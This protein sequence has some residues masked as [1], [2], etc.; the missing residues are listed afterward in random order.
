MLCYVKPD[1]DCL[2]SQAFQDPATT[3]S[4]VAKAKGCG[5]AAFTHSQSEV[6]IPWR[7]L[8]PVC[9]SPPRLLLLHQSLRSHGLT[10][11]VQLSSRASYRGVFSA[12]K[13]PNS[14]LT[15]SVPLLSQNIPSQ[16][17]LISV[18]ETYTRNRL[19]LANKKCEKYIAK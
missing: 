10:H 6:S 7:F 5:L 11:H 18:T 16:I 14:K 9:C 4:K 13:L 8:C 19:S 15:S 2:R 1:R 17:P 12:S 3:T